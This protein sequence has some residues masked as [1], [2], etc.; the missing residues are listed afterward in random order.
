MKT[1]SRLPLV[2]ALVMLLFLGTNA[3]AGNGNFSHS[4][5]AEVE[6]LAVCY[7]RGTDAIG[8]AVG[9]TSVPADQ[10]DDVNISDPDFAAGLALYRKCL[11]KDFSFKLEIVPGEPIAEVPNPNNGPGQDGPLQ[12]ANFVNNTF[13]ASGYTNTQHHMGSISSEVHG[14]RAHMVSYLIA[15]HRVG[16]YPGSSVDVVG[17]TYTD[18]VVREN[19]RWVILQRTLLLTS[20]VTTPAP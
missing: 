17:G 9:A 3:T 20:S 10:E 7:A 1:I 2:G 19:G 6:D 8:R 16:D 18:E 5:Q 14:N 12:W 11:S 4:A 13:R 15:T